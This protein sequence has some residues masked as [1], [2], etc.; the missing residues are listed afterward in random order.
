MPILR[1]KR[2]R[3]Q[4]GPPQIPDEELAGKTLSVEAVLDNWVQD[5]FGRDDHSKDVR[6]KYLTECWEDH[7]R[8]LNAPLDVAKFISPFPRHGSMFVPGDQGGG[9]TTI[10]SWTG[11][12]FFRCGWHMFS[13]HSLLLGQRLM[14]KELYSFPDHITRGSCMFA[15]EVH[16]I[17]DMYAENSQRQRT[18]GQASTALRR[19]LTLIIGASANSYICLLYTSPSPRDS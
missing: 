2:E 3:M 4:L 19:M 8:N 18:Y 1:T 9:K 11:E 16:T 12:R 5:E 14:L 15:D 17:L 10:A 7:E 13:S 6:W